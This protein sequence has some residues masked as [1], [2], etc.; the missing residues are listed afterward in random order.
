M[1]DNFHPKVVVDGGD[2]PTYNDN[3][4]WSDSGYFT[5]KIS[6]CKVDDGLPLE[7]RR[8][9]V[10]RGYRMSEGS[11]GEDVYI[12]IQPTADGTKEIAWYYIENE[13]C[14]ISNPDYFFAP[15]YTG[16]INYM[17]LSGF[18]LSEDDS[19]MSS[20]VN[21]FDPN[22][23]GNVL[24]MRG[25][26][27][28]T[29]YYILNIS[30]FVGTVY[31]PTTD[32]VRTVNLESFEGSVYGL[33]NMGDVS[34][35]IFTNAEFDNLD[36]SGISCSTDGYFDWENATIS[37]T[38]NMENIRFGGYYPSHFW[39]NFPECGSINVKGWDLS[40]LDVAIDNL[41]GIVNNLGDYL[42][43]DL[44]GWKIPEHPITSQGSLFIG[45]FPS[46]NVTDWDLSEV[47]Y[48]DR[49]F[50]ATRTSGGSIVGLDTWDVSNVVS[51][52]SL[53]EQNY[54]PS[55][56]D[57]EYWDVSNVEHFDHMLDGTGTQYDPDQQINVPVTDYTA[58]NYWR[59]DLSI[60][61]SYSEMFG[62]IDTS[63]VTL[64]EWNGWF[65]DDGTFI[66]YTGSEISNGVYFKGFYESH[67]SNDYPPYPSAGDAYRISGYYHGYFAYDGSGWHQYT[68]PPAEI[69]YKYF[70]DGNWNMI[71]NDTPQTT[72][73]YYIY[74]TKD[75]ST[76]P[77]GHYE[78]DGNEWSLD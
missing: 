27:F 5:Q 32:V 42:S 8:S 53:F 31:F 70:Y 69:L 55:L 16:S 52:V 22:N 48:L 46:I 74:D 41:D 33:N 37:G 66:P 25:M 36:L 47:T 73:S 9:N 4:R 19:P 60:T 78:W 28:G 50:Y 6:S 18:E 26:S 58:L 24:D 71:P 56:L 21:C 51:M 62:S 49:L 3:V 57:I 12:D 67:E 14:V 35:Y 10:K 64:P 54:V 2:T 23:S 68:Y 17:E 40:E 77:I 39:D 45:Y 61:A 75:T 43:Y 13:P 59:D 38:L 1:I 20:I 11:E 30:D 72:G 15:S 63:S 65:L 76:T 34:T 44:T 29:G 7:I